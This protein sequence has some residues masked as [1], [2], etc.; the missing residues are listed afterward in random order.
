[1]G[2][3]HPAPGWNRRNPES[4]TS[5]SSRGFWIVRH[6]SVSTTPKVLRVGGIN[7]GQF[8]ERLAEHLSLS[9]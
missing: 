6:S 3:V 4:R 2:I 5:F 7:H 1:M 9:I 8:D